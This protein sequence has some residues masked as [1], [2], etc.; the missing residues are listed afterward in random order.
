MPHGHVALQAAACKAAVC[1]APHEAVHTL[2]VMRA[3]VRNVLPEQGTEHQTR[4][5]DLSR[6]AA[7][8][9]PRL[10]IPPQPLPPA[11]SWAVGHNDRVHN[12]HDRRRSP[13]RCNTWSHQLLSPVD[14]ECLDCCVQAAG[15]QAQLR[16]PLHF[17]D[18]VTVLLVQV[19]VVLWQQ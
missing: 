8:W 10:A 13:C 1:V 18:P 2:G 16:D 12:C 7:P 11:S 5:T 15:D 14:V 4:Q 9:W 19:D 17:S 3:R 6:P